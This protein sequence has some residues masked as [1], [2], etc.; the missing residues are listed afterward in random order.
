MYN[1]LHLHIHGQSLQRVVVR[2]FPIMGWQCT[3][4][5]ST[6]GLKIMTNPSADWVHVQP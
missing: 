1:I 2:L 3:V 4:Y 6:Y 5:S